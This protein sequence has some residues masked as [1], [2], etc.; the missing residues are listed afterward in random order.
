MSEEIGFLQAIQER[1]DDAGLRL[2]Y[3]DWLEERGEERGEFLRL[4]HLLRQIDPDD[5]RRPEA[6]QRLSRLRTKM[7]SDWLDAIEP[8]SR[9]H[10]DELTRYLATPHLMRFAQEHPLDPV[11]IRPTCACI[12]SW[13]EPPPFPESN[14]HRE[15]QDTECAV[16]KRL[17]D[18][19]EQAAE[20]G[21]TEFSPRQAVKAHGEW[22]QLVT[23]LKSVRKLN[24][25]GS[26]LVRIPPEIGEMRNLEEFDPYTSHRLH[27]FPYEITRCKKLVRTTVSTRALYGNRKYRPPFPELTPV[28][29]D[30]E[31]PPIRNCSVCNRQFEDQ[32]SHRAWISLWIAAH[33]VLP[34]LV[35][36][37]S[38]AC[39][40]KVPKPPTGYHPKPHRGGLGIQQPS[41]GF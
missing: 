9:Q 19:I 37:C 23:R 28:P 8:E 3:A 39:I 4:Q 32:R 40:G 26:H 18:L 36:A 11:D 35:N 20:E 21:W 6:E 38:K 16:W 17:L 25:Y 34:L 10:A 22:S 7:S 12:D 24:L 41:P 30:G 29:A 14:F 33:D 15:A 2:V 1:P 31:T 5:L 27:W 13:H